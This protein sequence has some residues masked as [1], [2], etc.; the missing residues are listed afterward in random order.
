MSTVVRSY[1]T[2]RSSAAVCDVWRRTRTA[3]SRRSASIFCST[4]EAPAVDI[5]RR[6]EPSTAS[7]PAFKAFLDFKFIQEN[8]ALLKE[9]CK[10]RKAAA[11]PEEVGRLY[12]EYLSSL[13]ECEKLRAARNDNSKAM[14]V[15]HLPVD[16]ILFVREVHGCPQGEVD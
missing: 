11:D 1:L 13:H 16:R 5:E 6:E 8:A 9:N 3:R 7:Q 15:L 4:R 2:P 14:K 10:R 12:G